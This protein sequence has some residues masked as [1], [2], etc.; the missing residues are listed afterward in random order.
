[1]GNGNDETSQTRGDLVVLGPE[2]LYCPQGDFHIDP[3]RPVRRA[4]I[5][6]GHGDHARSG[7]GEYH[8][9]RESLSIL[10][11]RLG[12][13]VY[14]THADG[15]AF[16][17]GRARVSLHP[18][19]HVLGS[20]QVR[21]E[22]DGEV[23][24]ASGDY[25]RQPDP[26]CKPFEVVPCDT[27]ITEATF[28][29]PV[30]RWPDTSDVA[31]DIAAWRRECAE[32]GEAAILYCY[33]LGKAQRVLAELRAWETQPALLH[34]AVAVGVEVYRQAGIPML[35]TQPVSEHARG[36]DYAGQLVIA[37]PSAAGSAWIRRFRSAQ[38]GFASGWMRIRG[39][40]RRR[41]YDRGFV[42]SDHADWPDLLRTIE[43]TGAQRVIATHGNTDA[44]IQHLRER[45]VA[46]EAF[47]TDFGAEE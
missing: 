45:G 3:W 43:E 9:T 37:P 25:K 4:V 14:H 42:V 5:T 38:Q 41:N 2:G 24:V 36:A 29:L 6:H 20:A 10:Q 13:Q 27:F 16:Q 21:I 19:G 40:R 28:G 23:W 33:A 35:E 17:L 31:A 1:M 44:L 15:E 8:C 46:A 32:R 34:G 47:R 7:M 11:W 18:A 22:V 39:N 12:E 26:T 30:Y